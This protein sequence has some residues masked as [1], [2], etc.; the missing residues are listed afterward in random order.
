[1]CEIYAQGAEFRP[2]SAFSR[3]QL[4]LR[5]TPRKPHGASRSVHAMSSWSV[6]TLR[7]PSWHSRDASVYT[8]HGHVTTAMGEMSTP[9]PLPA[10]LFPA[11]PAIALF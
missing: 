1:M 6:K 7:A 4:T 9:P 8:L 3:M 11:P 2:T 10:S 5:A